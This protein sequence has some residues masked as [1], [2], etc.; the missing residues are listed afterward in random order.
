M[1]TS[2]RLPWRIRW[3][4]SVLWCLEWGITGAILTYLSLYFKENGL[5]ESEQ[6]Q[7]MAMSAFGLWVAPIIVG[8]IC[9]RLMASEKYLAVAHCAG[10]LLL[11][12]LPLV[13]QAY[14]EER[15]GGNFLLLLAVMGLYAIAYFPTVPV[16]SSLSFR[17]LPD[18]DAQFGSVRIWGT[19]GW[20]ASGV[21]L[22]LWLGQ[23]DVAAWL[24]ET[25]PSSHGTLANVAETFDW[26]P[27]P[28]S[29]DCFRIAAMLSFLL[30]A[31]CV[32]LPETPPADDETW[33]FA[34][35]QA[36][37]MFRR[38][39]FSLLVAISVALAAVV[40]FYTYAVPKMLEQMGF[41]SRWVPVTMTIGQISEFPAL[42][43]L[44]V[45]LKRYGLKITFAIGMAA[46]VVRYA[47]F[48]AD[49]PAWLILV[50]IA[51]N[52]VCHVFI[53]IVIQL[54]VDAN[55]RRDLR[56]SAQNLIAFLTLGI[57]MPI[58]LL[59]AGLLGRQLRI[60]DPEHAHYDVFFTIPAV[61]VLVLLAV[62]GRWFKRGD[63]RTRDGDEEMGG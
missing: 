54:Y 1:T 44:G 52:G 12:W 14:R 19:V 27:E 41:A 39:S 34:P 61:I 55:C 59:A 50:G 47:L 43:L 3:R 38:P 42:I 45:C 49:A 37:S 17:H 21:A 25:F 13:T 22:S 33:S 63:S 2:D 46:W 6:A 56:A 62:F 53:I 11:L 26:L 35:W 7:V 24:R 23:H 5:T 36:T 32:F 8:H 60:D 18:P 48:A 28:A 10:G 20:V 16:A 51:L 58:G 29:A 57:A 4:L 40:P 30:S 31:F 15:T 9:D